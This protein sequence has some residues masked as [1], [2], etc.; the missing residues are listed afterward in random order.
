MWSTIFASLAIAMIAVL[1]AALI[2][3]KWFANSKTGEIP[4]RSELATGSVL[5]VLVFA[6]LAAFLAPEAE[7]VANQPTA[8]W[9]AT[10]S[11]KMAGPW[12]KPEA[13]VQFPKGQIACLSSDD[14]RDAFLLGA[15]GRSTKMNA[16]FQDQDGSG[17]R[18]LM[19]PPNRNFKVIDSEVRGVPNFPQA[20]LLE[21]VGD[22]I[23]AADEGAY[24]MVPDRSTA[25]IVQ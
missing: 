16:Y 7:T 14:L 24:V 5:L 22:E 15:T 9:T 21:V 25:K 11:V 3:P 17:P 19:L 10:G 2:R 4:N 23:E 13:I 1:V 18:C 6:G 12:I 8:K 20:L